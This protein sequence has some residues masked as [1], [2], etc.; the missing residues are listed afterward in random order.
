MG[1]RIAGNM[2]EVALITGV[3]ASL[4]FVLPFMFGCAVMP[5]FC[6]DDGET[7]CQSLFCPLGRY[8]EIGS[9]VFSSSDIIARNLFD[10]NIAFRNEYD[11]FPLLVYMLFYVFLVAWVYGAYVPGGL[12][13]PSIVIGGCYGR[14]VGHIGHAYVSTSINPGVY[15]LLG[16]AGMLG[17]FT[18]LGLPVVVM[19]VEMTG[20]ATYLLPI[21]Y[22]ATLAKLL[23]DWIEP[24]LYPQH[25]AIESISQLG[26]KIPLAI[27]QLT[28]NDIANRTP[29]A[30]HDVDTLGHLLDTLDATKA[31]TLPVTD[32]KGRFLG[33]ITRAS[34]GYAIQRSHLFATKEQAV[35]GKRK[36]AG[37]GSAAHS[38]SHSA[39]SLPSAAALNISGGSSSGDMA[40]SELMATSGRSE[41][42]QA[43]AGM[44]DWHSTKDYTATVKGELS[45]L[46][47]HYFIN[48]RPLV[49]S[50]VFTVQQQTSNKRIHSMIRRMGYSHLFVTDQQ[51]KLIGTITRRQLITLENKQAAAPQPQ[52]AHAES[53]EQA[54]DEQHSSDEKLDSD[55][56]ARDSLDEQ[57]PLHHHQQ[58]QLSKRAAEEEKKHAASEHHHHAQHAADE[59]SKSQQQLR[60]GGRSMHLSAGRAAA[61][62]DAEQQPP[63]HVEVNIGTHSPLPH[64]RRT[65][66]Q[67][68]QQH[69]K[70]LK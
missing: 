49:D 58:Q 59:E 61:T 46:H 16:A 28:A 7:R 8:S 23:A 66:L 56:G 39:S 63:P 34:L 37:D 68:I 41:L 12:F 15:A 11:V 62:Y 40:E 69:T 48:I 13:V 3:T 24:P 22:V 1:E 51:H 36:P 10:R 26:D 43:G 25:M 70:D 47:L 31:K 32:D 9:I 4:M 5:P 20:D 42:L 54:A 18:R 55:S 35:R 57:Q 6:A 14:V 65:T 29:H 30:V 50:G 44:G 27:A 17:G 38:R 67:R 53:T 52:H 2:T 45:D 64:G 19:L 21:M 60:S 33:Q